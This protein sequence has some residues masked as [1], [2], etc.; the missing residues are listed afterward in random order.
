MPQQRAFHLNRRHPLPAR[1]ETI[2]A[3]THVVP[4]PL[5]VATIQIAGTNPAIDKSLGSDFRSL[6]V[7]HCGAVAFDPQVAFSTRGR[8]LAVFVKQSCFVSLEKTPAAAVAH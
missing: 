2:I 4:V 3:A 6:P 7:I 1:F 5:I 8:L